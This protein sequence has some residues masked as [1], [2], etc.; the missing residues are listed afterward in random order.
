MG[1][2]GFPSMRVELYHS[3]NNVIISS[4]ANDQTSS[5]GA[6]SDST[7]TDGSN[8]TGTNDFTNILYPALSN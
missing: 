5:N 7:S 2:Y 8:D 4:E 3:K 1:C 6:S